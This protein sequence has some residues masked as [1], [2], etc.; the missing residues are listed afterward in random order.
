[1]IQKTGF[2]YLRIYTTLKHIVRLADKLIRFAYLRIYTTLKHSTN[3]REQ[4]LS[5]AYLRIYT[6]LKPQIQKQN[7]SPCINSG[8]KTFDINYITTNFQK[9]K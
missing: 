7:A 4:V 2:A 3:L 5:F 9:K 8:T 1:M 6:T